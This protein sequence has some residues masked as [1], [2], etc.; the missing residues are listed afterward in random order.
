[1]SGILLLVNFF[2]WFAI[3]CAIMSIFV[4]NEKRLAAWYKRMQ[5]KYP[6]IHKGLMKFFTFIFCTVV[7]VLVAFFIFDWVSRV[8]YRYSGNYGYENELPEEHCSGYFCN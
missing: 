6:A 3:V 7:I 1:M 2:K 4:L 8:I 5:E